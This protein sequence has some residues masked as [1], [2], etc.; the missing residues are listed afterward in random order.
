MQSTFHYDVRTPRDYDENKK[1]PLLIAFHGIGYNENFTWDTFEELTSEFIVIGVRGNLEYKNGF[2]YY[3]LE[4]YGKPD[5]ASFE[6]CMRT[7][8]EFVK[9]IIEEYPADENHV[10][11][12]GFSQGAILSNALALLLGDTIR[13][14][15]SMNGYV[16]EFLE[17]EYTIQSIGHLDVFLS[18]G[19]DDEIFPPEIGK[20][21]EAYFKDKGADVSYRTYDTGHKVSDENR[22]H[23]NRWLLDN[24]G[25]KER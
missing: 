25:N 20:K 9:D 18:T 14:I 12:G 17:D 24:I 3:Y 8:P 10:Y 1:Y 6:E 7:M 22:V 21:N 2:A 13:G 15:V 5:M 16:P 19:K 11:M 4:G 23:A